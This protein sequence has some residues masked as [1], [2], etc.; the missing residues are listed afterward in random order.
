[1]DGNNIDFA[2]SE[3]IRFQAIVFATSY[4]QKHCSKMAQGMWLYGPHLACCMQDTWHAA[5]RYNVLSKEMVQLGMSMLKLLPCNVVDKMVQTLA[6]FKYG[7]LS[8]YSLQ[9]PSKGPFHL[10]CT[11]G[12]SPVIDVGTVEKIKTEDIR[13]LEL[14]HLYYSGVAWI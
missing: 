12:R 14:Q 2:S 9:I 7:D 4:V 1:M 5:C 3:T 11:T 8:R 6:K 10:K 13:A